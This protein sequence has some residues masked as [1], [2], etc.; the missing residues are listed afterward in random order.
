MKTSNKK[1][2]LEEI[3]GDDELNALREATLSRGLNALRRRQRRRRQFQMAAT[4]APLLFLVWRWNFRPAI[5]TTAKPAPASSSI[6]ETGKVKYITKEELFALFPD[7]PI[8]LIGKPG[9]QQ[10]LLLDELP[11]IREQ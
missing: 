2:L 3:L 5:P 8:A 10:F 7:R 9:H 11:R 6:A 4:I 1:P